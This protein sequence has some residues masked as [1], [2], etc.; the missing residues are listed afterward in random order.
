MSIENPTTRSCRTRRVP[1]SIGRPRQSRQ[2][3]PMC[4]STRAQSCGSR[5]SPSRFRA[6]KAG[7]L[8]LVTHVCSSGSRAHP[9]RWR[10]KHAAAGVFELHQG[11][12]QRAGAPAPLVAL[13]LNSAMGTGS[14]LA[15]AICGAIAAPVAGRRAARRGR[16]RA[17]GSRPLPVC[18]CKRRSCASAGGRSFRAPR[19]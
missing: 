9:D 7:R 14:I 2:C 3:R 6:S 16:S 17:Q 4:C 5:K 1:P 12:C 19:R 10:S 15:P 8:S 11:R 18:T 13:P